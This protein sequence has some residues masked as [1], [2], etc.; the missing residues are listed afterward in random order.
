M[1][2]CKETLHASREAC[3]S[4]DGLDSQVKPGFFSRLLNWAAKAFGGL[5]F[6]GSFVF[7]AAPLVIPVSWIS[8]IGVFVMVQWMSGVMMEFDVRWHK[9]VALVHRVWVQMAGEKEPFKTIKDEHHTAQ[10]ANLAELMAELK[11]QH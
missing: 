10:L 11:Q 8:A 6:V 9:F 4:I 5:L 7:L 1:N 2:W 3:V